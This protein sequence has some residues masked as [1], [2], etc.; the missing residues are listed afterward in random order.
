MSSTDRISD[1]EIRATLQRRAANGHEFSKSLL[2]QMDCGRR[3]SAAQRAAASNMVEKDRL[4]GDGG[5]PSPEDSRGSLAPLHGLFAKA[6]ES[7]LKRPAIEFD[8]AHRSVRIS[9]AKANS[10]NAGWLYV[11]VGGQYAG[12]VAPSGGL[13]IVDR[14]LDSTVVAFLEA[15]AKDPVGVT[16]EHGRRTGACCFCSHKLTD[17]T[18]LSVGYGPVCAKHYGLPYERVSRP[19][20]PKAEPTP[21]PATEPTPEPAPQ[22]QRCEWVEDGFVLVRRRAS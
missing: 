7:G 10:L 20:E 16:Q 4:G 13:R 22:V 3:L 17:A 5:S 2:R 11:R 19:T 8:V 6:K 15:L 14:V 21:E 18:S 1:L 9:P 12:K